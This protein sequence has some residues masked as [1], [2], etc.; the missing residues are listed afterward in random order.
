[1]RVALGEPRYAMQVALRA[2]WYAMHAALGASRC[3]MRVALGEPRYAMHA[4]LIGHGGRG[5][6]QL[7]RQRGRAPGPRDRVIE[8]VTLDAP[9]AAR[10]RQR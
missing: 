2:P 10:L 9:R 7:A 5:A 3:A 6:L 4:A 8:C 1:M